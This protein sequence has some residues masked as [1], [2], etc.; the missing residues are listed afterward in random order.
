MKPNLSENPPQRREPG[1]PKDDASHSTCDLDG[2]VEP[3]QLAINSTAYAHICLVEDE[4]DLCVIYRILFR[5][6]GAKWNCRVSCVNSGKECLELLSSEGGS[7]VDVVISDL[8]MPEMD[9]FDLLATL[10]RRF[11]TI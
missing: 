10:K 6:L 2:G 4:P 1:Q 8:K 5:K 11:P 7:D 9:G 3:S